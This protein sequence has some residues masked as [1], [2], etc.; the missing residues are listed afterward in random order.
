[1]GRIERV[2]QAADEGALFAHSGRSE[3]TPG[4]KVRSVVVLLTYSPR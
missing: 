3:S 4:L 1:M 2:R